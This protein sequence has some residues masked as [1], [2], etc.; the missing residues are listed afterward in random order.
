MKLTT[1]MINRRINNMRLW[2]EYVKPQNRSKLELL[3]ALPMLPPSLI[4][5]AFEALQDKHALPIEISLRAENENSH[6]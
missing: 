5:K 1:L 3:H 6:F 2:T 4:P